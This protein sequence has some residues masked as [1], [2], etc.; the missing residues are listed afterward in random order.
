MVNEIPWDLIL[1]N[2]GWIITFITIIGIG[3]KI[4]SWVKGIDDRIKKVEETPLVIASKSLSAKILS[5]LLYESF[6]KKMKEKSNP[7]TP[8]EIRLRRELTEKIDAGTITPQEARTL[9]AILNKELVEARALGNIV[10]VLAILF[11]LGLLVAFLAA[12]E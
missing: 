1:P 11:L 7:L 8:D 9:Q 12:G 10:A 2:L 3:Y 6:E 5:D 4:G